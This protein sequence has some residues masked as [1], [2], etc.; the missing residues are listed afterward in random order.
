MKEEK[1]SEKKEE[2]QNFWDRWKEVVAIAIISILIGVLYVIIVFSEVN[3]SRDSIVLGFF[4]ILTTFVVIGNYAQVVNLKSE[5]KDDIAGIK[6][7]T[8]TNSL[9]SRINELY[10]ADGRPKYEDDI[11]SKVSSAYEKLSREYN[12]QLKTIFD[13]MLTNQ[14]TEFLAMILSGKEV[15][16]KVR[17]T[18]DSNEQTARAKL[19]GDKII[20]RNSIRRDIIERLYTVNGKEFDLHTYNRIVKWWLQNASQSISEDAMNTIFG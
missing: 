18:A 3:L 14:H 7:E 4:G 6:D 11:I 8:R 1:E 19:E 2:K 15:K 12:I 20:F 9:V 16:C 17:E 13:F 5:M 10:G